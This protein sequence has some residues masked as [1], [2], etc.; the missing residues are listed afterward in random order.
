MAD[1]LLLVGLSVS[2]LHMHSNSALR[3]FSPQAQATQKGQNRNGAFVQDSTKANSKKSWKKRSF[4][5]GSHHYTPNG[6]VSTDSLHIRSALCVLR[7][8]WTWHGFAII[9]STRFP[10]AVDKISSSL[11]S[12]WLLGVSKMGNFPFFFSRCILRGWQ[13][14]GTRG[15]RI[16]SSQVTQFFA[17]Q[18][19]R[20]SVNPHSHQH[21]T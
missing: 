3:M 5:N 10:K 19:N 2:S 11:R 18:T 8:R 15:W 16:R 13:S 14:K 17:K 12:L 9:R 21:N 20:K 7:G 1:W 6:E 4:R